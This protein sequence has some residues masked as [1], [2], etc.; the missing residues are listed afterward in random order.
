[1]STTMGVGVKIDPLLV[2]DL[3]TYLV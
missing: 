3:K 2:K 1:M